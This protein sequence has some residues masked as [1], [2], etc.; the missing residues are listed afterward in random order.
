MPPL[1]YSYV[2]LSAHT[3]KQEAVSVEQLASFCREKEGSRLADHQLTA[4][5]SAR[6]RWA[7][8]MIVA[9]SFGQSGRRRKNCRIFAGNSF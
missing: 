8:D 3:G 4:L 6:P 7:M 9:G 2:D 1:M 5:Q